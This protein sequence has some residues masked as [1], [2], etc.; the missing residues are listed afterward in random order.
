MSEKLT[1]HRV[2]TKYELD[3]DLVLPELTVKLVI[4]GD[5]K[6]CLGRYQGKYYAL[7]NK[8]MHA[9]GSLSD[10]KC[11]SNGNVI[12]PFHR[13]RYS[14]VTGKN[15]SGEGYYAYS[16]PVEIRDDGL[17]IGLPEKKWWQF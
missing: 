2:A 4:A 9:G 6:I 15:T 3:H 5:K 10:G 17:Y 16:R 12:C 8:C 11:D 1:W 14:M 13:Y 7:D